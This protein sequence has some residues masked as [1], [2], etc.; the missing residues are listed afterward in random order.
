MGAMAKKKLHEFT[1]DERYDAWAR[2]ISALPP[3]AVNN[4]CALSILSGYINGGQE[5][6]GLAPIIERNSGEF[7]ANYPESIAST[8]RNCWNPVEPFLESRSLIS[9]E[10]KIKI[11]STELI[12]SDR[13][14]HPSVNNIS[15]AMLELEVHILLWFS[16]LDYLWPEAIF[17]IVLRQSHGIFYQPGIMTHLRWWSVMSDDTYLS[18]EVSDIFP[19]KIIFVLC[20]SSSSK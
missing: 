13:F 7:H 4:H 16:T 10:L 15:V 14:L 1:D 11:W 6:E 19:Y 20:S 9:F 3:T 8:I 12:F 18:R 5:I 2:I 17:V